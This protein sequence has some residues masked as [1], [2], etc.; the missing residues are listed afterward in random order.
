MDFDH[1]GTGRKRAVN[2][3]ADDETHLDDLCIQGASGAELQLCKRALQVGVVNPKVAV[4][5]Q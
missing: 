2:A 3:E 1:Q 4:A 5:V